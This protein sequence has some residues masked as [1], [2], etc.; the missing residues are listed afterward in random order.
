MFT[1]LTAQKTCVRVMGGG[2]SS[3]QNWMKSAIR[4]K[5]TVRMGKA[6]QSAEA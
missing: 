2:G 6:V 3:I 1:D 4:A 5:E